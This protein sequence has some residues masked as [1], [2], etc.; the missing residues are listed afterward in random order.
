MQILSEEKKTW[1]DAEEKAIRCLTAVADQLCEVFGE[2]GKFPD[3]APENM[4]AIVESDQEKAHQIT[5]KEKL[6]AKYPDCVSEENIGGCCGCPGAYWEGYPEVG[7][8]ECMGVGQCE[9]CWNAMYTGER[10]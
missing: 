8:R 7:D 5:L 9:A 2:N 6:R 10:E 4:K 1:C 3:T